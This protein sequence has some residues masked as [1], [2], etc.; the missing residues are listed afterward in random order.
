MH[1]IHCVVAERFGS[2]NWESQANWKQVLSFTFRPLF[3]K[4][5]R[6]LKVGNYQSQEMGG[7]NFEA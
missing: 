4:E 6:I 3:Q 1:E 5:I 2:D 7:E